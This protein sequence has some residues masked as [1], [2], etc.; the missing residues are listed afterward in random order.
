MGVFGSSAKVYQPAAE[1]DLGPGSGELYISPN[2]K[3]SIQPPC[4]HRPFR[5][6][7]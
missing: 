2:V 6:Y 7:S 5:G 1:V 3:G 4:R